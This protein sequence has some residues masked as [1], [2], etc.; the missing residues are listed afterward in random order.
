M[1]L[2]LTSNHYQIEQVIPKFEN[3]KISDPVGE[4]VFC[5][6]GN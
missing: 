6:Q 2:R 4:S 1:D 3:T 5:R